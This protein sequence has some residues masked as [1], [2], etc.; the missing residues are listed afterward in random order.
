MTIKLTKRGHSL[1]DQNGIREILDATHG[2]AVSWTTSPSELAGH[3]E[4]AEAQLLRDGVS[5]SNMVGTELLI[6]SAGPAAKA[7]RYSVIGS[8]AVLRRTRKE[9]RLV[10]IAR[11]TRYPG[12]R[13]DVTIRV[14]TLAFE[15]M[16]ARLHGRYVIQP[17]VVLHEVPEAS[18]DK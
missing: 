8:R 15:T 6:L 13:E 4:L 2:D 17:P 18:N 10:K 12:Q 7:Y 14:T 5:R 9:W 11:V 16:I 1:D 3:A